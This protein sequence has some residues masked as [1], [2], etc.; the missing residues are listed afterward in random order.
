MCDFCTDSCFKPEPRGCQPIAPPY[1]TLRKEN[2]RLRKVME[3]T[4][5]QLRTTG[6]YLQVANG[7]LG[8]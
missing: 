8:E 3:E 2:E 5:G 6:L 7:E 1:E 4:L